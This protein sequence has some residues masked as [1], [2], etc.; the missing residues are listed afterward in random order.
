VGPE[1]QHESDLVGSTRRGEVEAFGT[2]KWRDREKVDA[3]EVAVLVRARSVVAR[4]NGARLVVG[5]RRA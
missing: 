2:V 4:A 5:A 3:G 1:G